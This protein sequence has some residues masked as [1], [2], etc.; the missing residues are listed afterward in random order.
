MN[1]IHQYQL[2]A[3]LV[4]GIAV[5][6]FGF[7]FYRKHNQFIIDQL[8]NIRRHKVLFSLL[9]LLTFLCFHMLMAN[10]SFQSPIVSKRA[11]SY[12]EV[13]NERAACLQQVSDYQTSREAVNQD[14][15]K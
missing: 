3:Y 15:L 13:W 5:L 7:T 8:K 4:V 11:E 2:I 10:Y 12:T 14:I 6:L 1:I 9:A